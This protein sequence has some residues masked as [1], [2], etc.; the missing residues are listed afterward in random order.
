MLRKRCKTPGCPNLHTNRSGYCDECE[1]RHKA[2]HLERDLCVKGTAFRVEWRKPRGKTAERGYA[3]GWREFARKFLK[4]H[5]VCAICGAPATCVD[6]KDMPAEIMMDLYGKSVLD[7]DLYQALC[8]SCN[9]RKRAD[10]QRK[11]REYLRG[12]SFLDRHDDD[13]GPPVV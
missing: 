11:V 7:P 4:D 1:G 8:T 6:H 13:S 2:Q 10:D 3:G 9:N 12:R 5:P